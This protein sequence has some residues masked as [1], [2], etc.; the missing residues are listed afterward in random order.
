[1][2]KKLLYI[3][4]TLLAATILLI[5]SVF[6]A[7]AALQPGM[8]LGTGTTLFTYAAGNKSTSVGSLSPVGNIDN[9]TMLAT[10]LD[11]SR[12]FSVYES[13]AST[14]TGGSLIVNYTGATVGTDEYVSALLTDQTG[15][16]LYYGKLKSIVGPA[17]ASG[18]VTITVP[19]VAEETSY[20]L[21]LFSEKCTAAGD[22][23]SAFSRISL[24]VYPDPYITTTT[25]PDTTQGV[26]YKNVRMSAESSSA[27]V[28]WSI[29]GGNLPTGLT[30]NPDTGE[31]SGS[32][33]VAGTFNFN[34]R[35]SAAGKSHSRS[36]SITVNPAMK[37]EFST[38]INPAKVNNASLPRGRAITLNA[39]ITG[40]TPVYSQYQWLVNG[41]K[42]PG[43]NSLTYQLPTDTLGT[44]TY[45][46]TATDS[47]TANATSN[48][49]VT[50]RE[51]VNATIN[52]LTAAFDKAR[53]VDVVVTKI[54][55]DYP[56]TGVVRT[57]G[58][59]LPAG[60]VT[61]TGNSVAISKSY[62]SQLAPGEIIL[63][64]DYGETTADPA[65]KISIL[66]TSMP[67]VIGSLTAP[68]P[69]SRGERLILT[70]PSV[71]TYGAPVI[72]QGWKIKPI[73]A[74]VFS[75]F[76]PATVLDCSYNNAQLCYYATNTAG[77]S[78]SEPVSVTVKHIAGANWV[79]STSEHWHV[80][81][82]GVK[83][84][85]AK[86]SCNA[87]GDC[88]V[89]GYHC[90]HAFGEYISDNNATC[91][92]DG[93]KS[94]IC[95]LCGFKNTVPDPD[96]KTGHVMSIWQISP[97]E[98]WHVCM[99][100]AIKTDVGAHTGGTATCTEKAVCSVCNA[101]YGSL[102]P[103]T[104][105]QRNKDP[106]YLAQPKTQVSKA[107]YYF[108]CLCGLAGTAT[109]ECCDDGAHVFD[110]KIAEPPYLA[111]AATCLAKATYYY[112]CMC[113]EKGTET[114]EYGELAPHTPGA[115]AT[116]D[117]PQYCTVCGTLLVDKLMQ[118]IIITPAGGLVFQSDSDLT[119]VTIITIDGKPLTKNEYT[120]RY[121]G[122]GIEIVGDSPLEP[123]NHTIIIQ[124]P[125][126]SGSTD[127]VIDAPGG[128]IL[129]RFPWWLF[130]VI[131][132]VIG[133]AF[134]FICIIALPGKKNGAEP[135]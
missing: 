87:S 47:A 110:R 7:L 34:V 55:G 65:L 54:D 86:H 100:C 72:S 4:L 122:K 61:V 6:P 51:P 134:G 115:P 36:L 123:G 81:V 75:F 43:A 63:T 71:T 15:K 58:I 91:V 18:S 128:E 109:F 35:I 97:T 20:E 14:V 23:A 95:S 78:T 3:L 69:V 119:G 2:R 40:G 17:L 25:L 59:A 8:A 12:A 130:W 83:F 105:D 135:A 70:A 26:N 82:C 10:V 127:F 74:V 131:P 114:F 1:M 89:C 19:S 33:T 77:T 117:T 79:T 31:I 50:I 103:H 22:I 96:T 66:D 108:S 85:I 11:G 94:R 133:Y 16:I 52:P 39:S 29:S 101:P 112:S 132:R 90:T 104:F 5:L 98:H 124:T 88:T 45:S 42:I 73:S 48:I 32:P 125:N 64:F 68:A 30:L 102:K 106:K 57:A 126:G 67:P 107:T 93:T 76:D 13:S 120:L 21:L 129:G 24:L 60:A 80:C 46:F 37:I 62:L 9:P 99:K 111:T 118:Q 56:F 53:P 44:K 49:T 84:D 38:S 41:V 27:A 113:G 92:A 121:D 116:I 28:S